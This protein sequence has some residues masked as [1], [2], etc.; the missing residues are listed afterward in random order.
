[1]PRVRLSRTLSLASLAALPALLGGF[2]CDE[3]QPETGDLRMQCVDADSDPAKPVSF[4]N[5]IR[6]LM[7]GAVPGTKGCKLCHYPTNAAGTKEGFNETG[8]SLETL[9]EIR[10]GGR[11]TPPNRILVPGKP[12]ASAIVQKLQGTFGGARMPKEGPF[13]EPTK[14]QLFIDWVAE[15]AQGDDAD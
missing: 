9:R 12:C 7:N 11:N 3:I 5:D 1:V 8:L 6:P 2:G 10:I 14:I 13:W 15:G 4:K